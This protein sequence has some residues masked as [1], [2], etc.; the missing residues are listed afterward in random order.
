MTRS[1]TVSAHRLVKLIS[2]IDLRVPDTILCLEW[3]GTKYSWNFALLSHSHLK[4]RA[5]MVCGGVF[6]SPFQLCGMVI[7]RADNF[8]NTNTLAG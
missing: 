3:R 1:Q 2:S 5:A 4:F 8:T 6:D 7:G